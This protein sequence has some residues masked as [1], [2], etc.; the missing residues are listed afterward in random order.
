LIQ[1]TLVI[2]IT[3]ATSG[4][5]SGQEPDTS[6]DI[7]VVASKEYFVQQQ[8]GEAVVI[9]VSAFEAQF[10][11]RLSTE[12]GENLGES[13]LSDARMLPVFQFAAGPDAPRQINIDVDATQATNRTEFELQVTRINVRDNRSAEIASAYR[14]LATGLEVLP[15]SNVPDWTV[16]IQTILRA[17]NS[18]EEIGM[19]EM[20]LWSRTYAIHLILTRLKDYPTTLDWAEDLLSEPRIGRYPEI[21]FA[22]QKLR[23]AARAEGR[24]GSGGTDPA[25]SRLQKAL[26]ETLESAQSLD[27]RLEAALALAASGVDLL[28]HGLHRQAQERLN[29]ALEIA[30]EIEAAD[31]A[32]EIREHMVEIHSQ[33]GDLDASGDVLQ[34]I[35]THL[36]QEGEDQDLA[37]NL[38]R[39][40]RIFIESYRYTEAIDV[41]SRAAA[42][43]QSELTRLEAQLAL[44]TA[45]AAAGRIDEALIHLYRGVVQPQSGGFRRP[46]GVLNVA[47][48]LDDIAAIHRYKR[49]WDQL[50]EIRTAQ[51][52]FLNTPAQSAHWSYERALDSVRRNGPT[53]STTRDRFQD[54]YQ[55]ADRADRHDLHALSRLSLC[56]LPDI[57]S[58]SNSPCDAGTLKKDF[59]SIQKSGTP[60]QSAE[61]AMLYSKLLGKRG[62][63]NRAFQIIDTRFDAMIASGYE[64]LGAWYWQWRDALVAS[65]LGLSIN[66]EN[67]DSNT[68]A[69]NSLLSL[70]K[71]RMLERSDGRIQSRLNA[72]DLKSFLQGLPSN[73]AVVSFFLGSEGAWVWVAE[74]GSV[75]R[76][77]IAGGDRIGRLSRDLRQVM[78][79]GSWDGFDRLTTELG[80]VLLDPLAD[81][82]AE[83]VYVV[84]QGVL[85]GIPFDALR[86][87]GAPMATDHRVVH[88]DRF[89]ALRAEED[90][91]RFPPPST[92]FLAGDPQDWSGE[93]A[94]RLDVSAEVESV[95]NHFVGPGLHAIQ[96]VSLLADEFQDDRYGQ[97]ELVHLSVP[98]IV[99]LS[100]ARASGLFLSEPAR[101]Q[102]RQRLNAAALGNMPVQ[103]SL[104]FFSRTEF[105]GTGASLE[106]QLGVVSSVLNAGAGAVIA[107]LWPL[108]PAAR[109]HF[110]EGFYNRLEDEQNIISALMLTK[111]DS[112]RSGDP[113]DWASFQLFLN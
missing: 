53:S 59:E 101:G 84:S 8:A 64:P 51:R 28:D 39:Q 14:L 81:Y 92:T 20:R 61:S 112:M 1:N 10:E 94:N 82:L 66:S 98:G 27:Y 86:V 24:I 93:F 56:A 67:R 109:Q 62:Q 45:L 49:E 2:L 104:V 55:K 16:R 4:W 30:V 105:G 75:R 100:P 35:E 17:A 44:G 77:P 12:A 79:S 31:L 57:T 108:D 47:A 76:F 26:A 91:T 88:L 58:S 50:Q 95:S 89:P 74:R 19:E 7:P 78:Q 36:I 97:A 96:G 72:A 22:A 15:N 73:S 63:F 71:A 68:D 110:V 87:G 11:S 54:A 70:A 42:L 83:T 41:L 90:W 40:G 85:L 65:Y 33:V 21:A 34:D 29:S 102:G 6:D 103:A 69:T 5:V 106:N 113:R 37:L 9:R 25:E 60:R 107:S 80:A 46:S 18:F 52:S 23:S 13:G 48:A 99:D 32:A 38:L 43:E 3:L 111:R